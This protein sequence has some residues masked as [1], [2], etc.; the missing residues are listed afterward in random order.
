MN[1]NFTDFRLACC[2]I[3]NVNSVVGLFHHVVVGNVASVF[4]IHAAPIFWDEVCRLL[5]PFVCLLFCFGKEW[6]KG[7]IEWGLLP[8]LGQ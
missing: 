7:E 6:G 3:I 1:S 4:E 2:L 5:S 8:Y